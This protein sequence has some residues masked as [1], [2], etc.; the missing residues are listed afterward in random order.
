MQM[1]FLGVVTN[2]E[3]PDRV[4]I[5]AWDKYPQNK[6]NNYGEKIRYITKFNDVLAA[7]MHVHNTLKRQLL[8]SNSDLYKADVIKAIAAIESD[9]DLRQEKI[10][11]DENI[12]SEILDSIE[13]I[14]DKNRSKK[15]RIN[16]FIYLFAYAVLG[17]LALN[18]ISRSIL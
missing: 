18:F 12:D 6:N 13:D 9:D 10:W 17:L 14:I 5:V 8:D 16:F 1:G 7:K 11:M 2:T 4:K 15:K 3:F